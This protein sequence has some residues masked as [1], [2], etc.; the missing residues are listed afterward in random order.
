MILSSNSTVRTL[1]TSNR[2]NFPLFNVDVEG[3]WMLREFTTRKRVTNS[4]NL[5]R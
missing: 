1:R 3:I 5:A 4:L 2:E